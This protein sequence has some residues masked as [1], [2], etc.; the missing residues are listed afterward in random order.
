MHKH[1][2]K[3]CPGPLISIHKPSPCHILWTRCPGV[4]CLG[5]KLHSGDYE[6]W[7]PF[8]K[9]SQ[10]WLGVQKTSIGAIVRVCDAWIHR[11]IKRCFKHL[12]WTLTESFLP[13]QIFHLP[14]WEHASGEGGAVAPECRWGVLPSSSQRMGDGRWPS[15]ELCRTRWNVTSRFTHS[16]SH[17]VPDL[18]NFLHPNATLS[19]S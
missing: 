13:M 11:D 15:Q 5:C 2:E 16:V 14:I 10:T 7:A 1:H 18:S 8:S 4:F 3:V 6:I 17:N 9:W 12:N 19:S